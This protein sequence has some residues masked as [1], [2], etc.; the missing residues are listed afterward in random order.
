MDLLRWIFLAKEP[1]TIE[2]LCHALAVEP[3]DADLDWDNFVDAQFLLECCL[4]LVIVD[5]STSTVRLAHKSLQD[6][7]SSPNTT[8]A[9]YSLVAMIT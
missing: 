7:F 1:L 6:Y 5:E 4:G 9:Q 2:E 8:K 3:G